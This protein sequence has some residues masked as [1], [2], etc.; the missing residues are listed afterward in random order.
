MVFPPNLVLSGISETITLTVQAAAVAL[1]TLSAQ[2][3]FGQYTYSLPSEIEGF[4]IDE[5]SGVLSAD[6]NAAVGDYTLTVQVED[7]EGSQAETVVQVEIVA[8]STAA[9]SAVER[10]A[11]GGSGGSRND[12]G[13]LEHGDSGRREGLRRFQQAMRYQ[14]YVLGGDDGGNKKVALV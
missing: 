8:A 12:V 2:Y 3:G 13:L 4:K 9:L 10:F 6:G 7:E 5:S 11:W 1:H 14:T